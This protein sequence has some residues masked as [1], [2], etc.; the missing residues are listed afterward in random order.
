[1]LFLPWVWPFG[2]WALA[3]GAWPPPPLLPSPRLRATPANSELSF[4]RYRYRMQN[5]KNPAKT[6]RAC[7]RITPP[8]RLLPSPSRPRPP[9]RQAS[10]APKNDQKSQKSAPT[11]ISSTAIHH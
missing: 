4:Y 1:M 10:L 9:P 5:R 6:P 7:C 3:L 2:L 8:S 11:S